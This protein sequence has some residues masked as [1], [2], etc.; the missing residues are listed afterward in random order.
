MRMGEIDGLRGIAALSVVLAH[1]FFAFPSAFVPRDLSD[2]QSWL[3]PV[4]YLKYSPLRA[5]L[6]GQ[7]AVIM[8]F[9]LSGFVLSLPYVDHR[10]KSYGRYLIKRFCRI[11]LPF[12]VAI[13]Y[14]ALLCSFSLPRPVAALSDWFNDASWTA[15]P[16]LEVIGR[17]L[18]MTG[19]DLDMQLNNVMWSLV[20]EMR[21]SVVFPVIA[22]IL[23]HSLV[24]G[25]G[26]FL[27]AFILVT[28]GQRID[29][30]SPSFLSMMQTIGY[31]VFF[32]F[33]AGIAMRREAVI[34]RLSQLKT[35]HATLLFLVAIGCL[36]LPPKLPG[37]DLIFGL[38]AALLVSLSLSRVAMGRVLEMPPI[39]WLG[40]ISYSLYLCHLP[41]LLFLFERLHGRVPDPITIALVLGLSLGLAH[42]G[43]LYVERPSMW[44]ARTILGRRTGRL[45]QA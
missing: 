37:V 45:R 10:Q 17:H 33:G 40:R 31:M 24:G 3:D 14:A 34:A 6:G 7:P 41:L 29:P 32:A 8:F 20:H 4:T 39:A 30:P 43:Y 38:A 35:G 5:F 11:Y 28:I 22:V 36:A 16:N 25:L 9:T 19:Q 23:T 18:L 13:F 12:A 26:L 15:S 44:L 42:L 27:A 2:P 21:I 1:I